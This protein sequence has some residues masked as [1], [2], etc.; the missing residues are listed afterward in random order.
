MPALRAASAALRSAR[1]ARSGALLETYGVV[2]EAIE[3][4][5]PRVFERERLA[6]CLDTLSERERSVLVASF[7]DEE[8]TVELAALGA[9]V[10]AAFREGTVRAVISHPLYET[11]KKEG[12][13]LREYRMAPGESVQCTI[14]QTDD[15][16]VS[17]LQ[18][19]LAGERR[20]DLVTPVG[21]FEDI[22]FDS[23]SGG[24]S[25]RPGA[26]APRGQ[27]SAC[28]GGK[29]SELVRRRSMKTAVSPAPVLGRSSERRFSSACHRSVACAQ[30]RS[31]IL[32]GDQP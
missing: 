12:L 30:C 18:A 11:M 24:A 16:V 29:K 31:Q 9:A 19:P 2:E 23:D 10:G 32:L 14:R 28:M 3:D 22:P 27:A 21:R 8:P 15:F 7:F 13:Q 20:V 6:G 17:R 25:L 26:P 4:A 1:S 5:L